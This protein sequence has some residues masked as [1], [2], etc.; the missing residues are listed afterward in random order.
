MKMEQRNSKSMN[1]YKGNGGA[2]GKG[3]RGRYGEKEGDK[4]IDKQTDITRERER[5]NGY[6]T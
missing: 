6:L 5:L 3:G 4:E 1:R 2:R